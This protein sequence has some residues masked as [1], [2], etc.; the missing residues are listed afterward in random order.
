MSPWNRSSLIA[1]LKAI[2]TTLTLFL[3]IHRSSY[4]HADTYDKPKPPKSAL[5][6]CGGQLPVVRQ[7][8]NLAAC[9]S[10]ANTMFAKAQCAIAM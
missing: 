8:L 5:I 4:S 9:Q 2:I 3:V 1:P 6:I 10:K 7:A